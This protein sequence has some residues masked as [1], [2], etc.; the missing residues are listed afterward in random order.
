MRVLV[1]GKYSTTK[2]GSTIVLLRLMADSWRSWPELVETLKIVLLCVAAG[3][4]YGII[5]DQITARL[6]IEYFTVFHPPVFITH[7]P[8]LLG[9]GWGV[10]ATWWVGLLLGMWLALAARSGFRPKLPVVEMLRPIGKLLLVMASCAMIA[11]IT[12]FVLARR[13]VIV[14]P[15]WMV[16][17]LVPSSYAGFI[18]DTCAH[19]VSYATGLLG[20][21]TLCILQYRKRSQSLS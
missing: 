17:V 5:H 4:L 21:A 8:T 16:P 7:S 11:G 3:I 15:D 18:A 10:I 9:I 2:H 19:D 14:E 13:G 6:C 12:G 1:I 20:G